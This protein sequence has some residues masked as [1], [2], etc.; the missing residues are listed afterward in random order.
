ML[1]RSYISL[2]VD[3]S[4]T[5]PIILLKSKINY[6][7]IINNVSASRNFT[8]ELM[9]VDAPR[10]ST[11][12][13]GLHRYVVQPGQAVWSAYYDRLTDI[14]DIYNVSERLKENNYKAIALVYKSWAYSI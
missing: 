7:I 6:R 5:T 11:S 1:S 12:G 2:D 8:N 14:Q 3:S 10:S 9:Q 13:Q 4:I